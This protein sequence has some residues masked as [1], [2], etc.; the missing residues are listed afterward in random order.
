MEVASVN[1]APQRVSVAQYGARHSYAI[2]AA[3]AEFGKLE[4]FYTD[5]CGNVGLGRL[6]AF[7]RRTP[8]S[9][10]AISRLAGRLVPGAVRPATSTF[11][12]F[13]YEFLSATATKDPALGLRL[14]DAAFERFGE[15]IAKK[16]FGDSTHFYSVMNE[17]GPAAAAARA[18][19]LV[20]GADVCITPSWDVLLRSE[21]ER[22]PDWELP[23]PTLEEALGH[24]KRH[25]RHML[26]NCHVFVCPSPTVVEDLVKNHGVAR[27]KT[28]IV[29]YALA[30]HWF[31]IVSRPEPKRI[32]F[33]GSANVRKGI[34]HLANAAK[35]LAPHGYRFIVAG[36][37][38]EM[39][40][41]HPDSA[42][43]TF[44]GRVPRTKMR[45]EF[46]RAD[47]F[48]LPSI[49]EGSATVTYEAMAAGVPVV[50]S[51]A[52]GSVARHNVDGVILDK[53]DG[54]RLAGAIDQIS[55]DRERRATMARSAR[56]SAAEFTWSKFSRRLHESFLGNQESQNCPENLA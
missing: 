13:A 12:S 30:S 5:A 1:S 40:R 56:E 23:G 24:G 4:R 25:F 52:A 53:V 47:V 41:A 19:G 35:I 42:H 46:A 36:E 26:D 31:E 34:H 49:A 10:P 48:V 16:G 14:K 22:F 9:T 3:F 51:F 15:H 43:L 28:R 32:L 6:T 20:V 54:E 33:V 45:T 39:V 8:M 2:P 11:E 55:N 27:E 17:A 21:Q 38:S 7:I 50:A 18:G 37:V 44:L 29:P